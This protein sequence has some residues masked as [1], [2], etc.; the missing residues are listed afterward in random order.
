MELFMKRVYLAAAISVIIAS[1]IAY[2]LLML[3]SPGSTTPGLFV[4]LRSG[5]RRTLNRM[6]RFIA[7]RIAAALARRQ[8]RAAISQLRH[9]TDRELQD[10]GVYRGNMSSDIRIFNRDRQLELA[11]RHRRELAGRP[12]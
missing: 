1:S 4:S 12:W 6:K 7:V 5:M 3:G 8:R 10:I 9:M 2:Q 11:L